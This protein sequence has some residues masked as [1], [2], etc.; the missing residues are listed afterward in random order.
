MLLF[1]IHFQHVYIHCWGM[2]SAENLLKPKFLKS[3]FLF[4]INKEVTTRTKL[5]FRQKSNNCWKAMTPNS[6]LIQGIQNNIQNQLWSYKMTL[7]KWIWRDEAYY[8]FKLSSID[9]RH[10]YDI[11]SAKQLIARICDKHFRKKNQNKQ[12]ILSIQDQ[13]RIYLFHVL[14]SHQASTCL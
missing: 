13:L 4:L 3:S 7:I 14:I 8:Y 2:M 10:R 11:D 1:R 12:Q 9:S 5:Q 6:L